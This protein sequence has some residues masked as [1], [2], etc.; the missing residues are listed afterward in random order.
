MNNKM[1]FTL[2]NEAQNL[3]GQ[4]ACISMDISALTHF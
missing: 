1:Q 3:L 4:L 2:L